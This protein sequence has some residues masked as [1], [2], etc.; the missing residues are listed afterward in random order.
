[1]P[2]D[3]NPLKRKYQTAWEIARNKDYPNEASKLAA[4]QRLEQEEEFDYEKQREAK[5]AK[6]TEMYN[7]RLAEIAR[8]EDSRRGYQDPLLEYQETLAKVKYVMEEDFHN[9][10]E[11]E[12]LESANKKY[13][14]TIR[15]EVRLDMQFEFD[16][17]R[18]KMVA[19][20]NK[21]YD[22]KMGRL[23]GLVDSQLRPEFQKQFEQEKKGMSDN[24]PFRLEHLGVGRLDRVFRAV[25][26]I[27]PPSS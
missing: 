23:R 18:S 22:E 2:S 6:T 20:M 16:Q 10:K 21:E 13:V 14:E 11:K 24:L 9:E 19:A 3:L 26:R 17:D 12:F 15:K 27:R 1:M 5:N 7:R 4:L 8:K 25:S